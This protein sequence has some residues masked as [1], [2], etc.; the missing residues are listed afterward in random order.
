MIRTLSRTPQRA[1]AQIL[2]EIASMSRASG[3]GAGAGGSK[4]T[5]G[6]GGDRR[7]AGFKATKDIESERQMTLG[8]G[9][10][11]LKPPKAPSLAPTAPGIA[12]INAATGA[13]G[14]A[15]VGTTTTV[16]VAPTNTVQEDLGGPSQSS[17]STTATR[18]GGD[19]N[20][21]IGGAPAVEVPGTT[22]EFE[23]PD[24]LGE[25]IGGE[26]QDPDPFGKKLPE[27]SIAKQVGVLFRSVPPTFQPSILAVGRRGIFEAQC[28]S[29][30]LQRE[31]EEPGLRGRRLDQGDPLRRRN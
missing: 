31:S 21:G 8:S 26:D 24:L 10:L 13:T 12:G 4:P 29:I 23:L 30:K 5:K 25:D 22:D 7:S 17:T 2:S 15:T 18:G 27:N 14:D 3:S 20:Q 1:S 19:A 16:G 11:A 28:C 6:R 9:I